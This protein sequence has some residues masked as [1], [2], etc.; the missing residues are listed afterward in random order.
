MRGGKE[1]ERGGKVGGER[2]EEK[3][4]EGGGRGKACE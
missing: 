3:E 1:K 2:G 4:M